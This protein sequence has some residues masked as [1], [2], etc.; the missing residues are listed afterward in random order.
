MEKNTLTSWPFSRPNIADDLA[1]L[2]RFGDYGAYNEPSCID[3]RLGSLQLGTR[4]AMGTRR[5]AAAAQA[6]LR[7]AGRVRVHHNIVER[8]DLPCAVLFGK[9][10][11]HLRMQRAIRKEDGTR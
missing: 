10:K 2:A 9:H 11:L 4:G 6:L 5:D 3:I 7:R 8:V 1:A